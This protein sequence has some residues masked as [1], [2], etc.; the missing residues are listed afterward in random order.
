MQINKNDYDTIYTADALYDGPEGQLWK[1]DKFRIIPL[2]ITRDTDL[3]AVKVFD[4]TGRHEDLVMSF[5][6]K[7][8]ELVSD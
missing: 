2:A 6:H 8:G 4:N 7:D 3:V 5:R 1:G